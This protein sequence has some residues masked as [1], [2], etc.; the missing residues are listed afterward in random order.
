MNLI[1]CRLRNYFSCHIRSPLLLLCFYFFSQQDKESAIQF[2]K[3]VCLLLKLSSS[4]SLVAW[5]FCYSWKHLYY[6]IRNVLKTLKFVKIWIVGKEGT[7]NLPQSFAHTGNL[8]YCSQLHTFHHH[9]SSL[10]AMLQLFIA[11]N[12]QNW[13]KV[14]TLQKKPKKK[15]ILFFVITCINDSFIIIPWCIV[16][17]ATHPYVFSY[18]DDFFM[19]YLIIC[20]FVFCTYYFYFQLLSDQNRMHFKLS[21]Y[22][23]ATFP[24]VKLTWQLLQHSY[25]FQPEIWMLEKL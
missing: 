14:I 11:E 9:N 8:V 10:L 5:F 20:L 13:F 7:T 1:F 24:S 2:T 25:T 6:K 19:Q 22:I 18:I 21:S 17:D 12:C 23:V 15:N 3:S 4:Y 16:I